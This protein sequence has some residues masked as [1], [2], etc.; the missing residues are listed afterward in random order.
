MLFFL[1][2]FVFW[3]GT[4]FRGCGAVLFEVF[5]LAMPTFG[6]FRLSWWF[7]CAFHRW[8]VGSEYLC[9]LLKSMA[10]SAASCRTWAMVVHFLAFDLAN[11]FRNLLSL[12]PVKIF[13][14][15]VPIAV[16]ED[17]SLVWWIHSRM[18]CSLCKYAIVDSALPWCKL[19]YTLIAWVS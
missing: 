7:L 6:F 19:L 13:A 11:L 18:S 16:I 8:L 15:L 9:D 10:I 3:G 1:C 4:L 2:G 17:I 5:Y 12:R 14:W